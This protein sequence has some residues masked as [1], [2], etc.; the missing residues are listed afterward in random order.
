MIFR[1]KDAVHLVSVKLCGRKTHTDNFLL[2]IHV[3]F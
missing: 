1:F 2:L 3:S